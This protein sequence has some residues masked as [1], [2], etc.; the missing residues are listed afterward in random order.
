MR[1]QEPEPIPGTVQR[2][3]SDS[4][5]VSL[6]LQVRH[7][8]CGPILLIVLFELT[9]V[10]AYVQDGRRTTFI[11]SSAVTEIEQIARPLDFLVIKTHLSS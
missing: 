8:V 10:R 3:R 4:L 7:Y 2:L 6:Y 9:P 11:S 1:K 5:L